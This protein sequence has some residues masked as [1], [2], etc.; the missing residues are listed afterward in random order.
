MR[1]SRDLEIKGENCLIK[2]MGG[3]STLKLIRT[4][5]ENNFITTK[6]FSCENSK[7]EVGQ[8]ERD[9]FVLFLDDSPTLITITKEQSDAIIENI[10]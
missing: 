9:K 2:F 6:I 8:R 4:N 5:N 7:L 3:T 10:L 1:F